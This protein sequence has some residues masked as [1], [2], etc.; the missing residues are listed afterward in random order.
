MTNLFSARVDTAGTRA[1]W[2]RAENQDHFAIFAT[3]RLETPCVASILSTRAY[4]F[5]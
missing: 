3:E 2:S 4:S 1:T 5:A